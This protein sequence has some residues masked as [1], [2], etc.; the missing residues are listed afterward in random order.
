MRLSV[1]SFPGISRL[2]ADCMSSGSCSQHSCAVVAIVFCKERRL[3]THSGKQTQS[4]SNE[5]YWHP[6]VF[7]GGHNG[8]NGHYP[9]ASRIAPAATT[10]FRQ[11]RA[12]LCASDRLG[13]HSGTTRAANDATNCAKI[14]RANRP[15]YEC[16]FCN[17][18]VRPQ[19]WPDSSRKD[20][21]IFANER[22][23]SP[24]ALAGRAI[25]SAQGDLPLEKP[26]KKGARS[27]QIGL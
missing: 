9:M 6:A 18:H 7:K 17:P 19:H 10:L 8:H 24:V 25:I 15:Q 11:L 12:D 5:P 13:R 20:V 16:P 1:I 2:M 22:R 23:R 21:S 26:P 4:F 14:S 3:Y 27:L